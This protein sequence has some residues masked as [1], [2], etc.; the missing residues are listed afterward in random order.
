MKQI[1]EGLQCSL[2][3][4]TGTTGKPPLSATGLLFFIAD[5]QFWSL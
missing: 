5:M 1:A 2:L 4:T 3:V